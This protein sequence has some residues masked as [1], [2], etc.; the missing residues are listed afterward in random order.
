[1]EKIRGHGVLA[2]LFFFWSCSY[3][4]HLGYV[5]IGVLSLLSSLLCR[6]SNT[7][8]KRKFALTSR[9]K[10][11]VGQSDSLVIAH[12]LCYGTLPCLH[13]THIYRK[14]GRE[15]DDQS[16]QKTP[17]SAEKRCILYASLLRWCMGEELERSSS[18]DRV[19]DGT[20]MLCLLTSPVLWE[21]GRNSCQ[22]C[23][24]CHRLTWLDNTRDESAIVR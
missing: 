17:P 16:P 8:S 15:T 4:G 7:A 24:P 20:L 18:H 1:M 23:Q 5:H 12:D 21:S 3:I 6:L 22:R 11:P 19:D 9:N 13:L 14:T 2:L 10:H